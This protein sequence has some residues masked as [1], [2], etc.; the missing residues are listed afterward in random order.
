MK[1]G[2]PN[3]PI[4]ENGRVSVFRKLIDRQALLETLALE[5]SKSE[6]EKHY[7]LENVEKIGKKLT[8]QKIENC[9]SSC[10]SKTHPIDLKLSESS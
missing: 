5:I 8:N 4:A 10:S 9:D 2:Y 1:V 6:K 3:L 7:C